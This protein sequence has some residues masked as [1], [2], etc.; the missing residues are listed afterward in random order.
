LTGPPT[1]SGPERAAPLVEF[2]LAADMGPEGVKPADGQQLQPPQ[3][4]SAMGRSLAQILI[5]LI[6]LL[7]LVNIPLTNYRAGL[8]QLVPHTS[9]MVI[10]DGL[11]LQGSGPEIYVVQDYKLHW[12]SSREAF[13]RYFNANN[14]ST[15]EDSFLEQFG[16]GQ[17]IRRL[18]RC[19]DSPTVYAL[20]NGRKRWVKDPPPTNQ[21]SAWDRV[22]LVTCTYLRA[23]PT[24]LPIP[25]DAGTP[26][27]P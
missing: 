14:V 22:E 26:P 17:P 16:R 10:Y 27:Q 23:L 3:P 11:L 1:I 20:E 15:V 18:V 25:E 2:R 8:V 6:V 5:V 19:Q 24:G 4:S 13:A 12:I 21:A 9:A 7:V